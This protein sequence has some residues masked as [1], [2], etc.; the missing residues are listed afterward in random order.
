[1]KKGWHRI[2]RG[3]IFLL[4]LLVPAVLIA[5]VLRN[6]AW[7][8]AAP[9]GVFGLICLL[10]FV[11]GVLE[12]LFGIGRRKGTPEEF[13]NALE[14]YLLGEQ[15]DRGWDDPMD[16]VLADPRLEQ[17]RLRLGDNLIFL[18]REEDKDELRAVIAALRR[19]DLP[20]V[21]P[22]RGVTSLSRFR[23]QP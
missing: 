7:L 21:P 17:V 15:P 9:I 12:R 3:P 10:A 18:A 22:Q 8:V 20:E 2:P 11:F 16:V 14:K 19:G 13:A 5:Y 4:V 6:P 1:V 23:R